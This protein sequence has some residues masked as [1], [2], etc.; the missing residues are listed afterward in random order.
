MKKLK[1]FII[2]LAIIFVISIT[3]FITNSSY[4]EKLSSN[5][6]PPKAS[7]SYNNALS[8]MLE[9]GSNTNEYE[10]STSTSWPTEGY[11]FNKELS[12]CENGGE[13]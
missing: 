6:N 3:I 5:N 1:I 7:K 8:I 12:R 2:T 9:T 4:K 11:E 10:A 13:L